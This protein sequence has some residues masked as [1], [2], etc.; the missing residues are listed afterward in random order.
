[1]RSSFYFSRTLDKER[2]KRD[3]Q[4][5]G[6][7]SK[8]V[9]YTFPYFARHFSSRLKKNTRCD[10]ILPAFNAN[11]PY[12]HLFSALKLC[13]KCFCCCIARF[14]L[15]F[16]ILKGSIVPL[17]QQTKGAPNLYRHSKLLTLL[18]NFHRCISVLFLNN[19]IC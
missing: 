5:R 7:F 14:R 6:V 2:T 3:L 8:L 12:Y 1:V 9:F 11:F 13:L 15:L 16:A 10:Q 19:S 17:L 4:R 18:S